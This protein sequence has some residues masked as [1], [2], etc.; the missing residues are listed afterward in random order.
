VLTAEIAV[1][2]LSALT[3]GLIVAPDSWQLIPDDLGDQFTFGAGFPAPAQEQP[4]SDMIGFGAFSFE[5]NGQLATQL[6]DAIACPPAESIDLLVFCN[7]DQPFQAGSYAVVYTAFVGPLS[8]PF[9]PDAI[10]SWGFQTD[11][12]GDPTTGFP[13]PPDG[14]PLTGSDVYHE[15]LYFVAEGGLPTWYLLATDYR[16]PARPDTGQFQGNLPTRSR[17]VGPRQGAAQDFMDMLLVTP[18]G[19][20]GSLAGAH[21]YCATDRGDM[22]NTLAIDALGHPGSANYPLFQDLF[23]DD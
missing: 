10:C 11:V 22:A 6:S 1:Q 4:G 8:E 14:H 13:N 15:G 12:D 7:Q 9:P 18:I 20:F 19:D 3:S 5:M 16:A 2:R 17:I 23:A 21:A